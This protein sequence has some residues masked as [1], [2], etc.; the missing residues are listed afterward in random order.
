MQ[1]GSTVRCVLPRRYLCCDAGVKGNLCY[2]N[3][4]IARSPSASAAAAAGDGQGD[5][6]AKRPPTPP[7]SEDHSARVDGG[8]GDDKAAGT[9]EGSQEGASGL[10]S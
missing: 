8:A 6:S 5:G 4:L 2:L 10:L 7:G 9:P 1:S 3:L